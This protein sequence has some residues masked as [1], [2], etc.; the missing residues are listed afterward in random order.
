MGAVTVGLCFVGA[1]LVLTAT[2]SQSLGNESPAVAKQLQQSIIVR[3]EVGAEVVTIPVIVRDFD[4]TH[5]DFEIKPW[6]KFPTFK[7]NQPTL[8]IVEKT[9]GDDSLPVYRGNITVQS[10]FTFDQWYRDTPNV[11]RR[12]PIKLNLTRQPDGTLQAKHDEFFPLDFLGGNLHPA[13]KHKYWFTMEIHTVFRYHGGETFTFDGGDLWVFINRS[14]AIDLGGMH[15][16]LKASV[17]LDTLGLNKGEVASLDLFY[18]ERHTLESHFRVTTTINFNEDLC[19]DYAHM[20]LGTVPTNDLGGSEG[21][22]FHGTGVRP[23]QE[24]FLT[25]T[26]KD[27]STYSPGGMQ[28][29]KFGEYILVGVKAGSEVVLQFTF[30]DPTTKNPIT[31]TKTY[32][33]LLDLD[34]A[35]S[36]LSSESVEA[37]GFTNEILSFPTEV[38]ERPAGSGATSFSASAAGT[39]DDNP[40]DPNLLTVG[41]KK[42]AVTLEF[43]DVSVMEAKLSCSAGGNTDCDSMFA[44]AP[45][46]LCSYDVGPPAP[47]PVTATATTTMTTTA[48]TTITTLKV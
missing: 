9:L 4:E 41:Q 43:Q 26:V 29:G 46:L 8:G 3:D 42:R 31:L 1:A 45:T 23:Q 7:G 20:L 34:A 32:L 22:V 38:L 16:S 44:I 19:T 47:P 39:V 24:L 13:H 28:N 40:P 12:V 15:N 10:K 30:R 21:L 27:G 36:G 18:A 2:R 33:S 5:P 6:E 37:G 48:T 25:V 14:L 35:S 17:N 11:N